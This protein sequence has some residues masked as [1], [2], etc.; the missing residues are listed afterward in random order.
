MGFSVLYLAS[1]AAE[2]AT[3][4]S[5][6]PLATCHL[7]QIPLIIAWCN[8]SNFPPKSSQQQSIDRSIDLYICQTQKPIN[9][10]AISPLQ[11]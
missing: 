2:V 10:L 8:K 5:G 9:L 1:G 4:S 11:R 7:S 3:G 6:V